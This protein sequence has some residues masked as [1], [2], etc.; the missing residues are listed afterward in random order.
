[1]EINRARLRA[2]VRPRRHRAQRWPRSSSIAASSTRCATTCASCSPALGR[3]DQG[4]L[5]ESDNVR[6]IEQRIQRA[7][8]QNATSVT[9][10]R[11]VGS[12]KPSRALM[13]MFDLLA[14]AWQA[15]MTRVFSYMLNR[16]VSQ[17]V[18][19]IN[20]SEPHHA[21]SH[22]GK[23]AKLDPVKL[24]TWQVSLFAKFVERLEHARRRRL[25]AG[26]LGDLLGQRHE[27]SDLHFRLDVHAARGQGTGS[28]RATAPGGRR[29]TPIGNFLVDVAQKFGADVDRMGSAPA[30]WRSE[31][32]SRSSMRSPVPWRL[33]GGRLWPPPRRIDGRNGDRCRCQRPIPTGPPRCTGGSR[34]MPRW[35][36]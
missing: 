27:R 23:D 29:E 2:A 36:S 28:T 14:V 19:Q 21:M 32:R 4:R 24:N 15:D 30:G 9:C 17:R 22:H 7:E 31:G 13:L 35:R 34:R 6:E 20:A 25:P 1:M 26:S 12:R 10:R 11:A 18:C 33:L 8:K 16:D 3:R 5:S